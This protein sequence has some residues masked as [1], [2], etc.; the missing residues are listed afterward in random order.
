[1]Y[2]PGIAKY[3]QVNVQTMSRGQILLAL[4][5]TAIRY[6]RKAAESIRA[7]NV[8]AKGQEL[9]RVSSIV[10]E[11]AST[12]DRGVSPELC[13]NLELLYFYMQEKISHA[14][15]KMDAEAIEEVAGLLSTLH[16]AWVQAVEQVEGGEDNKMVTA[17]VG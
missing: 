11:L 10:S 4:Y 8:V 7:G 9:Q 2:G 13:D 16:E 1:M 3:K 6:A 12:L 14:N 5:E 15:I 17:A